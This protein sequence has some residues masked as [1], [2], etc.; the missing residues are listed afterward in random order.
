M[1]YGLWDSNI[2]I[3]DQRFRSEYIDWSLVKKT[4]LKNVIAVDGIA[5]SMIDTLVRSAQVVDVPHSWRVEE[6]KNISEVSPSAL[7]KGRTVLQD[8]LDNFGTNIISYVTGTP[9]SGYEFIAAGAIRNKLNRKYQSNEFPVVS[10]A[11]VAP[12][13]RGSGIGSIIVWHRFE[14]VLSYFGDEPKAIHFGT[15]SEK[16]LS[17]V[18]RFMKHSGFTR[19]WLGNESLEVED[20]SHVVC[21]YLC[22][23]PKYLKEL[24]QAA[25]TLTRH[26]ELGSESPR[27]SNVELSL[28][29]WSNDFLTYIDEGAGA[30]SGDALEKDFKKII[31]NTEISD[32]MKLSVDVAKQFLEVRKNIG[33]R[34]PQ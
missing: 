20:G 23:S 4:G 15:E 21:D 34:D 25:Q 32:E 7:D 2:E 17:T 29:D 27:G 3:N 13:S 33:A 10:R 18:S 11:V 30:V 26:S 24:F 8:D 14:T 16:I 12:S 6:V 22:L 1:H 9:E 5:E 19:M 31:D 28:K